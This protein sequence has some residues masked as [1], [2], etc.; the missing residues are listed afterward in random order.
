MRKEAD[1][2][3]E[4]MT[5][6][7]GLDCFNCPLYIAAT[8]NDLR[9]KLAEKM[10]VPAEM[11]Q[12]RGCRN[13]NGIIRAFGETEQC[14][15]YRCIKEKNLKFC[16]ECADFPC[17]RLHPQA[18]ESSE[19]NSNNI[20]VFNLCLIKKMGLEKWAEESS[21]HVRSSYCQGKDRRV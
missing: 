12:C 6:P 2:D 4:L 11:A 9:K 13:E 8:D 19:L 5:A 7:C 17:I 18:P 15:T 16:F 10:G 1:M 3:Y 20:K 21:K 14:S